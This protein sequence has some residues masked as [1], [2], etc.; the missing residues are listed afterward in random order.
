M[1]C[2]HSKAINYRSP[3]VGNRFPSVEWWPMDLQE[4]CRAC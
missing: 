4:V 2:R 3:I 1:D